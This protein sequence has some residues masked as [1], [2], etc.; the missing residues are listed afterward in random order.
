MQSADDAKPA[1]QEQMAI[2]LDYDL[3]ER[4][5]KT[6]GWATNA[7]IAAALGVSERQ[8]SRVRSRRARPGTAF[9]AGLIHAAGDDFR[10]RKMFRVV[11]ESAPIGRTEQ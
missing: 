3:F 2:E 10:L 8:V 7:Q 5:A 6:N 11:P 1:I 9:L 4:V